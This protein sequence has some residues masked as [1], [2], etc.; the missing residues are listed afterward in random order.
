MVFSP[1]QIGEHSMAVKFKIL[2][3][4][5]TQHS[6]VVRYYTDILTEDSLA[7]S[8]IT[9]GDGNT[10]I[11]RRPDGSPRRCQTDYNVSIWNVHAAQLGAN[12]DVIIQQINECAPYDWFA[13][14]EKILDE[15]VDTDMVLID[16]LIGQTYEAVRPIRIEPI[17]VQDNVVAQSDVSENDIEQL[18]QTILSNT[19]SGSSG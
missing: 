17:V 12:A 13:L 4:D 15:T 19:T 7:T 1:Y 18:I 11:D 8:F 2:D 10:V 9:D 3:K 5:T 16:S 6:I 14:K